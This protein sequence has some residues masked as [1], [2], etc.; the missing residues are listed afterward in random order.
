MGRYGIQGERDVGG[1]T[2]FEERDTLRITP[3]FSG[4]RDIGGYTG[5]EGRE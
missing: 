5:F 2:G 3:D 1:D 4:E